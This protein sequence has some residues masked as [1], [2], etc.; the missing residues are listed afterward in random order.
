MT[1]KY[2]IVKKAEVALHDVKRPLFRTL[3][4]SKP[5]YSKSPIE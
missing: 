3:F 2:H 5:F 4:H 1:N